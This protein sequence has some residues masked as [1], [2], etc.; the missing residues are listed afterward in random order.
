MQALGRVQDFSRG[1]RRHVG[2]T[3]HDSRHRFRPNAGE[4]RDV[5]YGR[6]RLQLALRLES[7]NG[8]T[9]LISD[10]RMAL[11][12]HTNCSTPG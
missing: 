7:D 11:T 10:F 1:R 4:R 6:A 2:F 8:V 12:H 9:V 5:P 3:V